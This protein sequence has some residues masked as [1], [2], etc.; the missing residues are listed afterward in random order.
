MNKLAS[1]LDAA[2]R[3][4]APLPPERWVVATAQPQGA[5]GRLLAAAGPAAPQLLQW[6]LRH[7][8]VSFADAAGLHAAAMQALA[9]DAPRVHLRSELPVAAT[10]AALAPGFS[11]QQTRRLDLKPADAPGAPGLADELA[12]PDNA[13]LVQ[14]L[15]TG[16]GLAPAVAPAGA[17]DD[18]AAEHRAAFAQW[19][20]GY[21]QDQDEALLDEL[22]CPA[23]EDSALPAT[24]EVGSAV[25]GA[26][27]GML[28]GLT[29]FVQG[30]RQ[31]VHGT[32]G[33]FLEA[34]PLGA[35][36]AD[37]HAMAVRQSWT[38]HV[39]GRPAEATDLVRLLAPK[40]LEPWNEPDGVQIKVRL[41]A[42][43]WKGRRALHLVLHPA[44]HHKPV[45]L[46]LGDAD[47][48]SRPGNGGMLHA[49]LRIKNT[50]E[51]LARALCEGTLELEYPPLRQ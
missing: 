23:D 45:R 42:E 41:D 38:L 36:S 31:A 7:G 39:K 24:A 44:G 16:R 49:D 30:V 3:P 26:P 43:R 5:P 12:E 50:T 28:A 34:A 27:A 4:A 35:E 33:A 48:L 40:P 13:A 2:A 8:L 19:S 29:E 20:A 17:R 9:S 32:F 25:S 14:W 47:D 1:T 22:F 46:S 21:L 51:A 10:L 11:A 18:C 15:L 6:R 37:R